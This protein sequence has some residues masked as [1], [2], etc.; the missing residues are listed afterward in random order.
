MKA[1][2]EGLKKSH[3]IKYLIEDYLDQSRLWTYYHYAALTVMTPIS[4]GTPNSALEAMSA[5]CPLIMP[6]LAYDK[7]IFENT[8]LILQSNNAEDLAKLMETALYSYNPELLDTAYQRAH[9]LGNR[10]IEMNKLEKLYN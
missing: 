6:A 9:E 5:H 2:L 7:D 4:D 3:S 1:K 10:A 8:C